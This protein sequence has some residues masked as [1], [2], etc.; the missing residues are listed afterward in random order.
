M[1]LM[2]HKS[3]PAIEV[4]MDSGDSREFTAYGNVKGVIDHVRDR[5]IDGCFVD[6]IARHEK[7]GTMPRMLWGHKAGEPPVGAWTHWEED[8]KGLLMRGKIF[9]AGGHCDTIYAGAKEG[10]LDQFSIGYAIDQ[11]QWNRDD[12]CNDL[13]KVHVMEVSW[14]N[15][16]CNEASTLQDIKSKLK[17]GG[18]T[19]RDFQTILRNSG[20]SKRD[21][22]KLANTHYREKPEAKSIIADLEKSP[23]FL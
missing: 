3:V 19:K 20:I 7:N 22:E 16:A 9:S 1:G 4:K 15:F 18:L 11:E 5:T 21:A 23:L 6:S 17:E 13:I 8:S 14:V 10:G 2:L 12:D